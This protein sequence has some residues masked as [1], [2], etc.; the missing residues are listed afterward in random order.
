MN[1]A[2]RTPWE[3]QFQHEHFNRDFFIRKYKWAIIYHPGAASTNACTYREIL[4]IPTTPLERPRV[5][6]LGGFMNILKCVIIQPCYWG[7]YQVR[8]ICHQRRGL[9]F[10]LLFKD[11]VV[12]DT[13]LFIIC[14]V[15]SPLLGF[16]GRGDVRPQAFMTLPAMANPQLRARPC[17]LA[18]I[19]LTV[20]ISKMLKFQFFLEPLTPLKAALTPLN[21]ALTPLG[22]ALAPLNLELTPLY[23]IISEY[24]RKAHT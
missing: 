8:P 6:S 23:P 9:R 13:R 15:Q 24:L 10:N 22:P 14:T 4:E 21:P 12:I 18:S 19:L 7:G 17:Q 5:I 20:V 16:C 1:I 11:G 3:I 2:I